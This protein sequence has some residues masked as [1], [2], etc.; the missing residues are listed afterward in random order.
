MDRIIEKKKWTTKKILRIAAAVIL[1]LFLIKFLFFRD[2]RSKLNVDLNQIRIAEVKKDKFQE[3]IPIDGV[4]QPIRTVFVNAIQGGTVERIYVEDGSNLKKGDTILKLANANLELEYMNRETNMY[5]VLNNLH[6]T[7]INIE[8]SN[9][10][11]RREISDKAYQLDIA[12]K[13]FGRKKKFYKENVISQ[14]E[15]ENAERDFNYQKTQLEIAKRLQQID[16][17]ANITRLAQIN[18]T[19]DRMSKNLE[20]LKENLGNLF[21]KSPITG[22]LSSFNVEI[23]ETKSAGQNLGHLDVTDGYKLQ[24]NIDERYITRVFIGQEA[25]FDFNGSKYYV[26]ISKIYTQVRNGSFQVDMIFDG[27]EPANVKRGQTLQLRLKFSSPTD[28]LI[29]QRGGFFQETGGNWI[30]VIDA[31]EEFA[32]KRKIRLGRQNTNYYEVL[33]GLEPGERV[34]ISS[35][36]T[37]GDKDMLI[38]KKRS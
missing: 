37:F 9:F 20:L 16:S 24:A 4:V 33:E 22:Q 7:K 6:N 5:E 30:Y 15:Y 2:T 34:I 3:F 11:R 38:L 21:I 35:Y 17:L 12:E 29:V 25:E 10:I 8:Q 13:D 26:E 32:L 23:G 28:A 19:I 14:E 27:E 31:A 36:D 18:R 1:G